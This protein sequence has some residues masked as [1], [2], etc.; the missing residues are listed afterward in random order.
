[1]NL[2]TERISFRRYGDVDFEFLHSLLSDP[3]MVRYIGEGKTRD[4]EGTRTFLEWIY[5]TYS[6]GQAFGLM[7]LENRSTKSPI[8]HAGLVPQMINGREE[9]EIGYW[10]SKEYWGAGYATEAAK[11]LMVYGRGLGINRFIAL[12]QPENT[13]SK[14]VADKLGMTLESE[15]VLS[16]QKV[17]VHSVSW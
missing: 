6:T 1:M 10:I 3:E 12:I 5:H 14:K 13:V 2:Q 4:R 9:I 7:V 8:G 15:I 17:H 16:G 11:S